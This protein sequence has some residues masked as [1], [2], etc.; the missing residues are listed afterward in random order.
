MLKRSKSL[1]QTLFVHEEKSAGHPLSLC[2][3]VLL[4]KLPVHHG[5]TLVLEHRVLRGNKIEQAFFSFVLGVLLQPVK[6]STPY[7]VRVVK[8]LLLGVSG[9]R[10]SRNLLLLVLV[11]PP[12][13]D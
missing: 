11:E 4:E 3:H 6:C 10:P 7:L 1:S 5:D 2:Y 8:E 12:V 9:E 13:V